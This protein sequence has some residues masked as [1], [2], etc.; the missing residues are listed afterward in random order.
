MIYGPGVKGNF[1]SLMNWVRRGLP[2]PLGGVI[3]NR[4]SLVGLDNLVDL[5]WVCVEHPKAANQTFL[6]SDTRIEC[7]LMLCTKGSIR[8][9]FLARAL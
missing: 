5:I 2:L 8:P 1:S 6:I 4:R 7:P 9:A 3:D